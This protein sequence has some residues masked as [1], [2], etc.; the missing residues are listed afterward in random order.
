MGISL[1][2]TEVSFEWKTPDISHWSEAHS[3]IDLYQYDKS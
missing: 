3:R 1:E 2:L